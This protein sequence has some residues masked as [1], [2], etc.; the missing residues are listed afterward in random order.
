MFLY[1]EFQNETNKHTKPPPT[2]TKS[3]TNSQAKPSTNQ[4][5]GPRRS[6]DRQTGV[7][8]H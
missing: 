8:G 1:T 4:Q 5:G 6:R 7:Q 2:N 3:I